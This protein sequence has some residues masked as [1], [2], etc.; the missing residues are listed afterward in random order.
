MPASPH[1]QA[2]LFDL[3]G[4]LLDTLTDLAESM[5][6][7]LASLGLPGHPRQ[8]YRYFVGDGMETLAR[9]VLPATR[10]DEE[11]LA[12]CLAA[13][14][15][16]YGRRWSEQTRPYPGIPDLLDRLAGLGLRLAILSNKPDEFTRRMV[17]HF[18]PGWPWSEV[19]GQ[20]PGTPRKPAPDG[21]LAI[22]QSLSL[23]PAR[24]FYLGDTNT[25]MQ[26][27]IASGMYPLG[28][29]WGFRTASELLAAGGRE[30]LQHPR[31]LLSLLHAD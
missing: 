28:A 11:T 3:D 24:F 1:F 9:R 18:L 17:N 4:T 27:A 22:A 2:V 19:R 8:A 29:L 21:A 26:T 20:R 6:A 30:L 25:D 12:R 13:M 31:E 7:A 15:E 5:N 16:E 14:R 10:R 23:P